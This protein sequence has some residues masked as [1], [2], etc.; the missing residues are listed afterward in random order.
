LKVIERNASSPS[1]AGNDE[2]TTLVTFSA[3]REFRKQLSLQSGVKPSAQIDRL[4]QE[5]CGAIPRLEFAVIN[6]T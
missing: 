1:Y 5:Q 3:R 4:C 2:C 6:G